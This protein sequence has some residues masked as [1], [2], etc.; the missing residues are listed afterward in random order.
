VLEARH[1]EDALRV[2]VASAGAIHL[3][4]TDVVMPCMGGPELVERLRAI[5]PGVKVLYMSGFTEEI[6]LDRVNEK[7]AAALIQKPFTLETLARAVRQAIDQAAVP[8][9]G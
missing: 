4:L 5:D 7:R 8:V 3:V 1:G 6:M 2:Y 9:G